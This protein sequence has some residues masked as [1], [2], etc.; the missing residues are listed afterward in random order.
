MTGL[1]IA[2][3]ISNHQIIVA[4]RYAKEIF[5]IFNVFSQCEFSGY[6]LAIL[7]IFSDFLENSVFFY[8]NQL[9]KIRFLLGQ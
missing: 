6:C 9:W 8:A 1:V 5:F 7:W 2:M 4:L 3:T